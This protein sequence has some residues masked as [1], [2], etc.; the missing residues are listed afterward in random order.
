MAYLKAWHKRKAEIDQLLHF[1]SDKD[2][3]S[4][5]SVTDWS[6]SGLHD[7]QVGSASSFE[8]INSATDSL[9]TDESDFDS[10][11]E[12]VSS[13]SEKEV[14]NDEAEL[15]EQNHTKILQ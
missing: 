10:D 12:F 7:N 9:S 4:Q 13:D 8:S 3:E 14:L 11:V 6:T 2:H 5:T 15:A 1:D